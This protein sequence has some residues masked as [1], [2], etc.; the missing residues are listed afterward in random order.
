M[1]IAQS[2]NCLTYKQEDLSSGPQDTSKNWGWWCMLVAPST[3]ETEIGGP[4][5]YIG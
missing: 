4:L 2:V 5:S 1:K 3:I